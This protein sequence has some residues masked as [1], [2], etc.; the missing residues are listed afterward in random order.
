MNKTE[1]N[2][3][4]LTKKQLD[5]LPVILSSKSLAEGL[6]KANVSKTTYYA[7]LKLPE[8]KKELNRIKKEIVEQALN[9]LK[10]STTEAVKVLKD[11]LSSENEHIQ[12]RTAIKILDFTEK[13]MEQED[14]IER[15][16]RFEER[17]K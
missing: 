13:F 12:L 7:W 5:S 17:I 4:E 8:Y 10:I 9:E 2:G 16:N 1:Q 6:K 3:T 14:I 11:L 15:L